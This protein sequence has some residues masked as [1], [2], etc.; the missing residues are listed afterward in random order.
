MP[1]QQDGQQPMQPQGPDATYPSYPN[2][3]Q[4]GSQVPF[5]VP[6][7]VVPVPA[8]GQ[9]PLREPQQQQHH[10]QSAPGMNSWAAMK[11]DQNGY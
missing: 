11:G 5:A 3:A 7:S 2:D 10:E 6:P 1:A 8:M 4:L 9:Q